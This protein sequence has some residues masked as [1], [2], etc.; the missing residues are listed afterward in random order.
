M[1]DKPLKNDAPSPMAAPPHGLLEKALAQAGDGIL[2]AEAGVPDGPGPS[3]VYVNEA[4]AR[5]TG[6]RPEDVVGL[7]PRSFITAKTGRE[8]LH[9]IAEAITR[10]ERATAEVVNAQKDGSELHVRISIAPI[11]DDSG[12]LTH[13][14]IVQRDVSEEVR[15]AEDLRIA[16]E[17]LEQVVFEHTADLRAANMHMLEEVKERRRTEEALRLARDELELHVNQRTEE[18]HVANERLARELAER[19]AAEAARRDSEER[20]RLLFEKAGEAIFIVEA[21]DAGAII[22]ANTTAAAMHGYTVEELR[23]LTL[24]ELDAPEVADGTPGNI[25]RIGHGEWIGGETVHMRKDGARFP[26]DFSAGPLDVDDKRFIITFMRDITERKRAE[27]ELRLAKKAADAASRAKSA[28]LANMSHEIRTPMNAVLGYAQLLHRDPHL[29]RQ[30]Q[31]HLEVISRS[32]EHLL[33]LI[34]DVLEMS[35]I[36]IGYQKLHRGN[37]DLR[38][39]L[40]DLGQMFLLRAEAKRLSFEI[41]MAS[42][43]PAHLVADERKL[44]QVLINLL[45]NA[46]KFTERGSVD[47]RVRLRRAPAGDERLMVEVAD[48]GPGIGA[49]K[50]G[51]LFQPFSQVHVGILAHGGTGLG[52]A[53]SREFARL[54]GG[55]VTVESRVGEGSVFRLEV[56]VEIA[57]EPVMERRAHKGRVMSIASAGPRM[58]ILLADDDDDNRG[59]VR[60]LLG[61]VGFDVR[62]AVN[63]ADALTAFNDWRPHLVLLDVHMPVVDGLAVMRAIRARPSG[64]RT[65]VVAITASAFDEERGAILEAGADDVLRKPCREADLLEEIRKQLG[66]EYRYDEEPALE[67]ASQVPSLL[68]QPYV[69]LESLPPSLVAEIREAAHVADY[70][71]LMTLIEQIPTDHGTIAAALRELVERFGYDEIEAILGP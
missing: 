38:A 44:R 12:R 2:I 60:Q 6:Y 34:N 49:E 62:E 14:V 70:F 30:Q 4:F 1:L 11:R 5:M 28:F 48:S 33:G 35:R 39:M 23:A 18:L 55:D 31:Q 16:K 20:Y 54:M 8:D 50:I 42:D 69:H 17:G 19:V 59:W 66:I 56:P 25:R 3:I 9:R 58:R 61:Q 71:R 26:V 36:E 63:G 68:A 21:D 29:T 41:H 43:L 10:G 40:D 37:F 57:V 47:V 32:G 24:M 65:A 7:S 53:L 45:G 64:R 67:R 27:E 22:E 13:F 15:A 46:V 52:L 51:V